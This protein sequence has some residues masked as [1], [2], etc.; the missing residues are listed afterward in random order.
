[1][2]AWLIV[3]AGASH[4][5]IDSVA[6]PL[7]Y[8]VVV[9]SLAWL[10]AWR[11][12]RFGLTRV[13]LVSAPLF[14]VAWVVLLRISPS[15]Y[16]IVPLRFDGGVSGVLEPLLSDLTHGIHRFSDDIA[17]TVLLAYI[18]WRGLALGSTPPHHDEVM[19]RFQ[20]S[21]VAFLLA[22]LVLATT[23]EGARGSLFGAM[24]LM[25]PVEVFVCLMAAALANV[26]LARLRSRESQTEE[27]EGRWVGS[28][29]LLAGL[30]AMLA[31]VINIFVNFESISALL[32]QLGPVG[33][34]FDGAARWLTNAF[35]QVL[36]ILIGRPLQFFFDWVQSLGQ[37]GR[38]QQSQSPTCTPQ[39]SDPVCVR[40]R[41]PQDVLNQLNTVNRGVVIALDILVVAVVIVVF[42]VMLKR[43]LA[44]QSA[45]DGSMVE[46]EREAIGGRGLFG[47]QVRELFARRAKK[48]Q[49]VER[50]AAGTVRAVYREVLRAA[51]GVGLGRTATETPSE[52][53]RRLVEAAPLADAEMERGDVVAVSEAYEVARYGEREPAPQ[54]RSA[55]QGRGKRVIGRLRSQPPPAR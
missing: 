23:G 6:A 21:M 11:F 14:L 49:A 42:V 39:S 2:E 44:R 43:L 15:A 7:W 4:L 9:M 38:V 28:A 51:A 3:F 45:G 50:L 32:R 25:L 55:L 53:A 47:A 31:L 12:E 5:G 27:T 17:L 46:E 30:V 29:L 52:Y 41:T 8:L 10:V 34:A 18:W 37:R 40:Q 26:S 13:L 35:I 22:L 20:W 16:G 24:S 36:A 1:M 19:R 33:V 54:E 48:E